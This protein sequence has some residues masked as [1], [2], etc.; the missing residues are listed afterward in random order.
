MFGSFFD[1]SAID[2]FARE[3]AAELAKTL[4]PALCESDSK[5]ARKGREQADGRLQ[6]HINTLLA[7]KRLNVYQKAQLGLR[8]QDALE[9]AGYASGF[10]KR[11]AY[12]VVAQVAQGVKAAP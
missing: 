7:T 11:F 4:P 10:A 3:V 1:T 8:L 6:R 2:A 5:A 9:A 12:E